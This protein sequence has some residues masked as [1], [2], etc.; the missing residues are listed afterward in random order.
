MVAG[1]VAFIVVVDEVDFDRVGSVELDVFS[2][3][4]ERP[5][6]P[7]ERSYAGVGGLE[8]GEVLSDHEVATGGDGGPGGEDHVNALS[9]CEAFEVDSG[10]FGVEEFD[11]L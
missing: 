5:A 3:V 9:D 2:V 1:P 7:F 8:F 11:E 10:V 4:A 6:V